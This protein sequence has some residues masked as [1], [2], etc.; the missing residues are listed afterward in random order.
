MSSQIVP[1]F[2][3]MA[4]AERAWHGYGTVVGHNM[5]YAEAMATARLDWTV[6]LA[7]I[8]TITPNGVVEV[9]THRATYR[10]DTGNVLGIVGADYHPHQPA[11]LLELARITLDAAHTDAHVEV[12]G[13]LRA[14]RTVFMTIALP[15]DIDIAGDVH[16]PRLVWVTSMDGTIATRAVSTYVRAVCANTIR[17]SFH[18]ARTSWA[19]RH[20]SNL[21]GR[22]AD[23]RE[24]LEL[25][26]RTAETF[27]AEV[28]AL[29]SQTITDHHVEQVLAG[30]WRDRPDA[31]DRI[32]AGAARKRDAVRSVYRNDDRVTGWRGTAYGL[33][34]A[35]STWEQW[36]APR[37]GER[38][39]QV[40]AGVFSG[41]RSIAGDVADRLAALA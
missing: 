13:S 26:F 5:T 40:L 32:R 3:T 2:D 18:N 25:M 24:A 15:D 19:A 21:N 6:R 35:A 36:E 9:H 17:A 11:E 14:G 23:A 38:G 39:E 7:P 16:M 33:V 4:L 28:E 30:I 29:T 27:R 41:G 8:T 34:Q 22:A 10:S 37:R 12:V 31:T 20:T 1:G